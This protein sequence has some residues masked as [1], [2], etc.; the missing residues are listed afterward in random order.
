LGR[1]N[2]ANAQALS[3]TAATGAGLP[4]PALRTLNFLFFYLEFSKN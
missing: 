1:S 2:F 4:W 3:E